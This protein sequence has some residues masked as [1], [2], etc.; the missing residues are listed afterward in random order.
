MGAKAVSRAEFG[1]MLAQE[2]ITNLASSGCHMCI[3]THAS[4]TLSSGKAS[5]H[6]RRSTTW[7][8]FPMG[9]LISRHS[10]AN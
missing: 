10:H 4:N 3:Q 1:L 8:L 5:L 9:N 7:L 2:L 6:Y